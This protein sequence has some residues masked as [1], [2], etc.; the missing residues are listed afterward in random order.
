M[1]E[2]SLRDLCNV[3]HV[4]VERVALGSKDPLQFPYTEKSYEWFRKG[5]RVLFSSGGLIRKIGS[6]F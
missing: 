2:D 5:L 4:S 1:G 3:R 6:L